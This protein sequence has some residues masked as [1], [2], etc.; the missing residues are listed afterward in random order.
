MEQMTLS[1]VCKLYGFTR[2][3]IQGYEKEGLI[4]HTSKNKYGY[5]VYSEDQIRKIAYIRYL[6]INGFTLKEIS[7][8]C[9]PTLDSYSCES[10][11]KKSN[12][13]LQKKI[14]RINELIERN[15]KVLAYCKDDKRNENEIL[16]T[17]MEELENEKTI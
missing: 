12:Q 11:L 1:Q 4:K 8:Y 7:S 17:I 10:L 9:K 15:N 14:V 6:Q 16:K 5:L 2:K 3:V 13:N